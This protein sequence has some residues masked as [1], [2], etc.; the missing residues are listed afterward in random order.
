MLELKSK[1]TSEAFRYWVTDAYIYLM[2]FVFPLFTGFEGYANVTLSKYL[3]LSAATVLWLLLLTIGK[4]RFHDKM[5]VG[6]PVLIDSLILLYLICCGV[7]ALASP[8]KG[9]SLLGAGRFDGLLTTVLCI[10]IFSG[11]SKN[12]RPKSSYIYAAAAAVSLNCIVAVLQILGYNPLWLFPGSFNFY[13]AGF[14]FSSTFLGTIGNADLFSA[15]LCLMLPLMSV[16]YI[17]ASRRPLFFLPMLLLN[18]FCLF[19]CGVS[20]GVLALVVTLLIAA[21]L[22]ITGGESLRRSLEIALL[23]TVAAF[24]ALTIQTSENVSGVVVR[25]AFSGQATV[26]AVLAAVL[27]LLRLIFCKSVFSR[28]QLQVFFAVLSVL[29]VI[30]GVTV[31]YFWHGTEGTVYE[32]SQVLHGN[33]DDH[34]G[35]SRIL[36][37]RKTLKLVPEKLLLGGGPGTLA[38]R[39]QIDFARYVAETGQ[40]LATTVDNAHNDYLAILVNTGLFSLLAYLAA[41]LISLVKAAKKSRHSLFAS[42]LI[43]GLLCYWLQAFFGLGLFLV[44]PMMW[45]LWGLLIPAL[46]QPENNDIPEIKPA[47]D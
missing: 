30:C 4:I 10:L 17:M 18:A 36:I 37:W 16:Y 34:F 29:T 47:E 19:V 40:T 27:F 24:S 3:F 11:V 42:C 22:I 33:W 43:C 21:P 45:L 31:V 13:D 6:A 38:L 8:D 39:L 46:K 28:K 41:Q 25:F 1:Q 14:E 23:F 7:S 26:C 20:G 2:L 12:A 15:Y 5:K 32:L 9:T 35:S 44:S